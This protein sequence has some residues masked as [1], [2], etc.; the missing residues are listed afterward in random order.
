M[1]NN[2]L[3][4]DNLGTPFDL[5]KCTIKELGAAAVL[6]YLRDKDELCAIL[7]VNE[8][9]NEL[10][11]VISEHAALAFHCLYIGDTQALNSPLDAANKLTVSQLCDVCEIY[12]DQNDSHTE[13]GY[14]ENFSEAIDRIDTMPERSDAL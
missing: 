8:K 1:N 7:S 11:V 3:S 10:A 5:S 2:K 14:N 12:L 4:N 9:D 6:Q 13:Q